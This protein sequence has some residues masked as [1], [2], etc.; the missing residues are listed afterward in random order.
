MINMS[1]DDSKF[2]EDDQTLN[3]EK[4]GL[5][6]QQP[7]EESLK[8]TYEDEEVDTDTGDD[9][10]FKEEQKSATKEKPWWQANFFLS[11]RVLFGA[12]DGV[13]TT[14]ILNIFGV[15]IF[16]RTGWMVGNAGVGFSILTVFITLTV[17]AIGAMSSIGICE[18]CHVEGG[19]VYFLLCHVL[20]GQTAAAVGI[21]YSFGQAVSCSLYTVGFGESI[22]DILHT[23]DN[24]WVARG[25]A[26]AALVLLTSINLAGVKWVI[27]LQL[28]LL[29]TIMVAAVDFIVGSFMAYNP[30]EGVIGYSAALLRNNTAPD[31]TNGESFFTVFGVF[32]PTACGVLSGINMSGDLKSPRKA[33][34]QGTIAAIALSGTFYVLFVLV[35]GSIA[36]RWTLKSDYMIAEKVSALGV[37]WLI[38]LYVSSI[39]SC[40]GGLYGAPRILQSIATGNN[41]PPP[42][43]YLGIGRGANKVPVVSLTLVA[44]ISLLFICVGDVNFLAPIVTMPFLITYIA[45]D[46]AYFI[47]AMSADLNSAADSSS[48]SVTNSTLSAYGS[49]ADLKS[50]SKSSLVLDENKNRN[51]LD[52]LFPERTMSR[53]LERGQPIQEMDG[54]LISS[55]DT[56]E[57]PLE[58]RKI[59]KMKASWYS[60]FCNRWLSL[61]GALGTIGIMFATQWL[62]AIIS[63]FALLLL[64]LYLVYAIPGA[65]LGIAKFS[66]CHWMLS[67]SQRKK[68][69]AL[70]NEVVL[71]NQHSPPVS[72]TPAQLNDRN[73]DFPERKPYHQSQKR[74]GEEL[75]LCCEEQ[76]D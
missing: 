43:S 47:L 41:F 35:L 56:D 19:G 23:D 62:Y 1:G 45:V 74:R 44:L 10:L 25:F 31:Y 64:Y 34:A 7:T 17:A 42:F 36:E 72:T 11:E 55:T 20:G 5:A 3:W 37:L 67:F 30:A 14:C 18:R 32:F 15:I 57:E 50:S 51:D 61:L 49:I 24:P 38:G 66:L 69:N 46:Y 71:C 65:S 27:R 6:A 13:F 70:A 48:E 28:I 73:L 63:V 16:L 54:K 75:P 22:S 60:R 9:E 33:I 53:S 76:S 40:M 2:N 58:A 29:F 26:I 12:W 39:T 4:Y 21:L 68:K 8:Q 59:H 52:D